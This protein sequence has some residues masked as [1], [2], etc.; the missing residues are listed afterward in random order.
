MQIRNL[1][2]MDETI[3]TR[4]RLSNHQSLQWRL[5]ALLAHSGD[6]WYW[7]AGLA[8]LWLFTR[9]NWHTRIAGYEIGVI[10]ISLLAVG[11]KWIF[12]R[13]RPSGDWLPGVRATDPHSF[14]SG[15]AAR[16][17]LLMTLAWSLGPAWLAW[18]L[19][20]WAPLVTFS[21]VRTGMHY[22]SDVIAGAALGILAA[23]LLL[24]ILP[25]LQIGLPF[26]F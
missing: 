3:T 1:I 6:S 14:P 13:S 9:G 20:I 24:L 19:T 15:H 25:F 11:L 26:L 22:L 17:F 21:R 5:A 23:K 12:R 18:L 7:A 8:I 4:M 16:A 2:Q 10:G